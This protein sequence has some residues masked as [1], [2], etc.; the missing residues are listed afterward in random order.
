MWRWMV[1]L[2]VCAG[3]G[4]DV[5]PENVPNNGTAA[6]AFAFAA[7]AETSDKPEPQPSGDKCENCDGREAAARE[8]GHGDSFVTWARCLSD[9]IGMGPSKRCDHPVNQAPRSLLVVM[10]AGDW[11]TVP[12]RQRARLATG[13]SWWLGD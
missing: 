6:A 3:C 12:Q 10:C 2:I 9:Y 7:V 13:P 5:T 4:P 11:A 8:G 1:L